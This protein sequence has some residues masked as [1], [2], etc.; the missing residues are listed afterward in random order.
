MKPPSSFPTVEVSGQSVMAV[1][2]AM[3]LGKDR[4]L[5]LL[6][7]H[8][9]GPV[10]TTRWYPLNAVLSTYRTILKEIGPGTMRAVGRKVP[11]Y[12]PFPP[13]ITSVE[14]ALRSVDTAYRMNHRG[15]G[16]I[17]G[18]HYT[19]VAPRSVRMLCDSPYPC[20]L[21]EGLLEALAERFKPQDAWVRVEHAPATCR[22]RGDA[23]CAYTVSW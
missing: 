10:D 2:E 4:A 17:G 23:S 13:D 11:E 1:V 6:A 22:Q 9:I 12:A 3:K 16:N 18:Y 5:K 21:D 20:Q 8:G 14:T 19:S 7:E 15:S